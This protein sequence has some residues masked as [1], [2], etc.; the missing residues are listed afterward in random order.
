[1]HDVTPEQMPH[2]SQQEPVVLKPG[3]FTLDEVNKLIQ[4]TVER[5]TQQFQETLQNKFPQVT[6]TVPSLEE[7]KPTTYKEYMDRHTENWNKNKDV[8]EARKFKLIKRFL[9]KEE[10]DSLDKELAKMLNNLSL[11]DSDDMDTTSNMIRGEEI[12]IDDDGFLRK[13]K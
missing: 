10:Q 8:H 1:M 5:I 6:T 9:D 3:Q 7:N 2:V 4:S 12:V 11:R 13:K